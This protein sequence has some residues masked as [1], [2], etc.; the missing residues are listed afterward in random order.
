MLALC[1][2]YITSSIL[3]YPVHQ[4]VTLPQVRGGQTTVTSMYTLEHMYVHTLTN[5][6]THTYP[7][8]V[9]AQT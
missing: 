2:L 6:N 3:I 7:P 5:V 9:H 4:S 8:H 1:V